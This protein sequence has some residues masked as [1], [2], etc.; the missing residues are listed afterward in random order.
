MSY[1]F[2]SEKSTDV[3][4]KFLEHKDLNTLLHDDYEASKSSQTPG[5]VKVSARFIFDGLPATCRRFLMVVIVNAYIESL[6]HIGWI[7]HIQHAAFSWYIWPTF[8]AY[9]IIIKPCIWLADWLD[10]MVVLE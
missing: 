2:L 7:I 4:P 1:I 8:E 3:L 9:F 6:L 10:A 5:S